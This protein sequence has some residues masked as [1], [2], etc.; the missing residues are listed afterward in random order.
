MFGRFGFCW[1]PAS[2][3]GP[4]TGIAEPKLAACGSPF[5][6]IAPFAFCSVFS[7]FGSAT[8][9]KVRHRS[10]PWRRYVRRRRSGGFRLAGSFA[11][12]TV[13]AN[14][15]DGRRARSEKSPIES[16]ARKKKKKSCH[17]L[18]DRSTEKHCGYFDDGFR[19]MY[20]SWLIGLLGAPWLRRW[21]NIIRW[22][23]S[24]SK[25]TPRIYL[26][27]LQKRIRSLYVTLNNIPVLL[28][29]LTIIKSLLEQRRAKAQLN[30]IVPITRSTL[31]IFLI[32]ILIGTFI[33]TNNEL[34]IRC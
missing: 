27:R 8:E 29:C 22:V 19:S 23:T 2:G 31:N 21:D 34:W 6:D 25:A 16:S 9:K 24:W 18:F 7:F 20:S 10:E 30:Q 3:A 14:F 11:D 28:S 26:N 12:F 1:S 32:A 5:G 17:S 4:G 15:R 33:G 13:L